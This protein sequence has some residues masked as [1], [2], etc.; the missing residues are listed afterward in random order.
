MSALEAEVSIWMRVAEAELPKRQPSARTHLPHHLHS[1][2][3]RTGSS[4]HS[5]KCPEPS[6]L[7]TASRAPTAPTFP[8]GEAPRGARHDDYLEWQRS[9]ATGSVPVPGVGR[10]GASDEIA[11][12][13]QKM[14][15]GSS[16]A[17]RLRGFTR[18]PGCGRARA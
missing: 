4:R 5:A 13:Q 15:P 10:D 6:A 9:S 2:R 11:G 8:T 18:T 16:P 12:N 1:Q 17:R 7:G 14:V 3:G